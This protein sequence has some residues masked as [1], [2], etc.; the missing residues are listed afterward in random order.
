MKPLLPFIN[1]IKIWLLLLSAA[2]FTLAPIPTALAGKDRYLPEKK[3]RK[4]IE[5]YP[6]GEFRNPLD[7]PLQLVAN[8]GELRPN[9]Y[10]MGLDI[11]TM[12]RENL[13]V[14]AV[15]DGY[16]RKVKIEKS[17]FGNA[18]Y[19]EHFN[20]FTTV[21]AHLN[22]FYPALENYVKAQQYK[23][24]SWEQEMEIDPELFVVKKG[25]FIALSGNTGGSQ[26]PHLHF[27]IRD[28]ET[29][30]N[31]NPLLFGFGIADHTPPTIY[32]L[33]YYDRH[34]TTYEGNPTIIPIRFANGK[35]NALTNVVSLNSSRVSFGISADDIITSMHGHVGIY[36]AHIF[37]DD[38]MKGGFVLNDISYDETRYINASIDYKMRMKG[39][40]FM[41]H[42]SSLP[43]N[44]GCFFEEMKDDIISLKDTAIHRVEILVKDVSGNS[45]TIAFNCKWNGKEKYESQDKVELM[46]PG[47]ANY[48]ETNDCRVFFSPTAFYDTLPFYH[49]TTIATH[50]KAVSLMHQIADF[51][52]PVQDTFIVQIKPTI[53]LSQTQQQRVVMYLQSN[54]RIEVEKGV[55]VYGMVQAKFKYLGN[56][57]L[58]LDTI[59]PTIAPWGWVNGGNF[60]SKKLLTL[61]IKDDVE[62]VKNFSAYLDGEWLLFSRKGDFFIHSFDEKTFPG[63]H[64]LKVIVED[65]AGNTAEK[66]FT[67]YR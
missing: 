18:I 48:F 60:S 65:E 27:E 17:G 5:N 28:T 2:L 14:Y 50:A 30:N 29:G 67:F 11:R 34:H 35:Y 13:P 8:F 33:A 42:I 58:L 7:I 6:Q 40:S 56:F 24:K 61:L 46:P 25:Q 9:H 21:Y 43:G 49:N 66:T 39:G 32:K 20:G 57:T 1:R 44:K 3:H 41:Q 26:G 63:K 54:K 47:K 36:S 19:I 45:S 16:V 22:S 64:Q 15:A 55:W 10:H 52:L 37:L 53:M 12:Q 38:E 51:T 62:D 31:L 59:A 23:T 4:Q